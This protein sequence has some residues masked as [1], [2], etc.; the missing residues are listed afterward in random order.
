MN[1]C[2]KMAWLPRM[3]WLYVQAGPKETISTHNMYPH[4][5]KLPPWT[6]QTHKTATQ[7]PSTKTS[8]SIMVPSPQ[9]IL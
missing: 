2:Y 5:S 8:H 1:A 6:Q 3:P 7:D 4:V 9:A